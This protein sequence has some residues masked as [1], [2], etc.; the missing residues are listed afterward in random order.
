MAPYDELVLFDEEAITDTE[1]HTSLVQTLGGDGLH[2]GAIIVENSLDQS[3]VV[4]MQARAKAGSV[5][6]T[7]TDEMT[8][9]A[10]VAGAITINFPWQ[11]LRIIVTAQVTPSSGSVSA[12]L[13]R[14]RRG[15]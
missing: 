11:L 15:A 10:G 2:V 13:S 4:Q 7:V 12:W 3:I 9:T 1:V 5:W 6:C 8:V 14:A